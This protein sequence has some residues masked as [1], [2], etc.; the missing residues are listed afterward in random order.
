MDTSLFHQI[1]SHL[2]FIILNWAT[3]YI[4]RMDLKYTIQWI[5]YIGTAVTIT[6]IMREYISSTSEDSSIPLL[7]NI[8]PQR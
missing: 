2:S 7:V 6:L 5:L 8:T 3:T 4:K 1:L